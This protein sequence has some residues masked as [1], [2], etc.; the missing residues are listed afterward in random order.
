MSL[1]GFHVVFVTVATLLFGFLALWAFVIAGEQSA[2]AKAIG[3]MGVGGLF[4]MPFYG[5]YFL[6]KARQIHL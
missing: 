6:R 3:F 1:K 4:C 5:V 2:W